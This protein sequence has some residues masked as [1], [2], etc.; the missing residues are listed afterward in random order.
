M[1]F[2]LC[3]PYDFM[4]VLRT[5]TTYKLLQITRGGE[6]KG[7]GGRPHEH[8]SRKADVYDI[9]FLG[10]GCSNNVIKGFCFPFG[11]SIK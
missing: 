11:S 2:V 6:G 10:L 7:E 9:N 8:S 3:T 5:V 4:Y 1:Y